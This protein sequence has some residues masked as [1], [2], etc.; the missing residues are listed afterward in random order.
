M[1]RRISTLAVLAAAVAAPAH[2]QGTQLLPGVTYDKTVEFTPH[3]AVV[4]HVLT[5]PRPG[6]QNGLYQLTP[7]LSRSTL[8][9][10][11]ERVT[12]IERDVSAQATVAGINGDL[13]NATSGLPAGVFMS[14]GVL[15]HPP[16]G[17]RSSI[18]IDSF[19]A[20]HVDRVK[21]FG[22]WRGTGQRRPLNGLNQVPAQG[23][24]VLL[25]P[26][27]GSKAPSIPGSAEV[28]LEPFPATAA[29]VDLSASVSA[30]GS[31]GGE[32]IPA[33]GAI[34]QA[35]GSLAVALRA[36]ASLGTRIATRLIL[37]PAWGGMVSALGGGPILVRNSA[38]VFRSGEDFTNDQV[39]ARSPRAGVGQL[40]DGRIILVAVDGD[41]PGYSAGLT[42][43]ELA[44][45]MARLGAVTAAGVASGPDVTVAFDG[46]LLNRPSAPGGERAVKEALLVQYFGVYAPP[47][48]LPLL[49]GEAG[50]KQEQLSYKIVRPSQVTAQ[51]IGPDNQPRV[52]EASVQ[53]DPGSYAFTYS[54]F[55]VE[56]TWHWNVI[57]TD[58]AKRTSTIDRVFRYD[59]TLRGLSVPKPARGTA[60]I[61]FTLSR[62][63]SVRLRIETTNGV[64]VREVPPVS[65]PA[66]A[67]AVVWDGRL[68]HGTRAYGG[69]YVAHV[70]VTSSV[71]TSDLSLP[72]SF[73]RS[74]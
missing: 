7:V 38:P 62:P 24:V 61:R 1:L 40:A 72:F 20:L 16:V 57:A 65:L 70:F 44:Q 68:P 53:H 63:A 45:T 60:A 39:T 12:Q 58:D 56:G 69:R 66:G 64:L 21:F 50:K 14:G 33:D 6:D 47:P 13:F 17:T 73:R 9:G 71:G 26:A 15:A 31:N 52:L 8:T 2:A 49:T 29:N 35:T 41:Q 10:G 4:L 43:F 54:S 36:E 51:L 42:G 18:G 59:T 55:D 23:Q 27:F 25:T 32:A 74:G 46:Q 30:T 5:A 37:Q 3:G 48:P 67:Q 11:R 22:T 19:G 34:L 28:V